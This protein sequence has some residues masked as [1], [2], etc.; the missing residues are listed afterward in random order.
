LSHV[1][2]K[3]FAQASRL[4]DLQ[5]GVEKISFECAADRDVLHSLQTRGPMS[6]NTRN[7][8]RSQVY[9]DDHCYAGDSSASGQAAQGPYGGLFSDIQVQQ[10]APS[11]IQKYAAGE[12]DVQA[13]V[14]SLKDSLTKHM[15]PGNLK[16]LGLQQ[17][18]VK[19]DVSA[20]RIL[21]KSRDYLETSIK[22]L[23]TISQETI[24][25]KDLEDLMLLQV[26]HIQYMQDEVGY[27][28][29]KSKQD[30]ANSPAD[31]FR[32]MQSNN[33]ALPDSQVKQMRTAAELAAACASANAASNDKR[34]QQGGPQGYNRRGGFNRGQQG[35]RGGYGGYRGNQFHQMV[36]G[37][38]PRKQF[39]GPAPHTD[40]TATVGSA[41]N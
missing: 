21:R 38:G 4:D 14:S 17:T 15:L 9:L 35:G 12:L 22:F 6:D 16:I 41:G 32:F 18:F 1:D 34:R 13:Y 10:G 7:R 29:V 28:T 3:I 37:Q 20:V 40:S 25:Q 31:W 5:L 30:K 36:R 23:S 2:H 26:A 8:H 39:G 27:F 33:Q 19:E 11:P 24:S